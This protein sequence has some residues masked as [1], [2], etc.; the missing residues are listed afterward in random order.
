MHACKHGRC[1]KAQLVAGDNLTPDP[2]DSI[3]SG[4]VSTRSLRL[5]IFLT[6]LNNMEVWGADI[7]NAYLEATTIENIYITTGPKFKKLQGHILVSHK[8]LYGLKSSGL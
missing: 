6:K 5:S 2:I 1:H 7:G 4:L 3:Y 8:A